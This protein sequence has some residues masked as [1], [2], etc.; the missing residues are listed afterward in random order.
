[1]VRRE[2][3]DDVWDE[4]RK[5]MSQSAKFEGSWMAPGRGARPAL[6]LHHSSVLLELRGGG[7]RASWEQREKDGLAGTDE[8]CER[9]RV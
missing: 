4:I 8:R 9:V 1:M 2:L 5:E 6:A 7:W 3:L